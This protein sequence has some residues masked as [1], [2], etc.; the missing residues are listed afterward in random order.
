MD[1]TF[2]ATAVM[3]ALSPYLAKGGEEIAKTVGKD[4][5]A[6]IKELFSNEDDDKKLLQATEKVN[7]GS[8]KLAVE[9]RLN[10]ILQEDP[11]A[12]KELTSLLNFSDTDSFILKNI[13]E[14]ILTIKDELKVLYPESLEAGVGTEGDYNNKIQQQERKLKKLEQKFNKTIQKNHH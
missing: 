5:Y 9:K 6:K 4:L 11:E 12:L 2:I 10:A 14:S 13:L 8:E 1:V 3:T 7:N